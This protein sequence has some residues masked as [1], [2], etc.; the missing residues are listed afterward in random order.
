M[1]VWPPWIWSI[2]MDTFGPD[3]NMR[4]WLILCASSIFPTPSYQSNYYFK[5]CVNHFLN[6][7]T[8]NQ[9]CTTCVWK[10]K[11]YKLFLLVFE[12]YKCWIILHIGFHS[13]LFSLSIIFLRIPLIAGA[14]FDSFPLLHRISLYRDDIIY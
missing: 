9:T 5:S 14:I 6:K 12:P 13:K 1:V 10:L 4:V 8:S 3:L 2:I 11:Q 7:K